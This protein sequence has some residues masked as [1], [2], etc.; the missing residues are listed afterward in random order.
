LDHAVIEFSL[1]L[2]L[3][4]SLP[5]PLPHISIRH[6]TPPPSFSSRNGTYK[7]LSLLNRQT[8]LRKSMCISP[9]PMPLSLLLTMKK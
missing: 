2:H 3:S 1:S 6:M 4:L 5:P 7:R 8:Q 9:L